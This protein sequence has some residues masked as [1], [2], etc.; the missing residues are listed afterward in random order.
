MKRILH[1]MVDVAGQGSYAVKGLK[2]NGAEADLV[3]WYKNPFSYSDHRSL[4]LSKNPLLAPVTIVKLLYFSITA[5]RKYDTFHFHFRHSLIPYNLDL[6]LLHMLHKK[7]F[8]EYH[9]SELRWSFLR[10]IPETWPLKTD[11]HALNR[12]KKQHIKI[13]KYVD[14]YILHDFELRKHMPPTQKPI[15]YIP[16]KIDVQSLIPNYPNPENKRPVIVHA[17]SNRAIKGTQ[18]IENAIRKLQKK[19]DFSFILVENKTQEEAVRIYQSAD[20]IIDQLLVGTY[21]VFAIEAMAMGKPVITN[22][23]EDMSDSFPDDCPLVN[24]N[25]EN[26]ADKIEFLLL[27]PELRRQLGIRGSQY[28]RNYHDLRY[29]GQALL[30]VYNDTYPERSPKEAFEYVKM[31]K[32]QAERNP[33]QK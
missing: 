33:V 10:N 16:L 27:H 31:L 1:G 29:V 4:H 11:T 30:N 5:T 9:G 18:Y 13:E 6:P 7:I 32:E 12:Q 14:G 2:Y 8:M 25:P 3:V 28:A 15:Y 23:S 26:I 20:I 19:Y 22:L 17:P 21:G 24:A